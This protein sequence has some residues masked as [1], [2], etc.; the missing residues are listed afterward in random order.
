MED[1]QQLVY[2]AISMWLLVTKRNEA[3]F[4]ERLR[5]MRRDRET[6][7]LL[8]AISQR[9]S[10]GDN[11]TLARKK[12]RLRRVS[13]FHDFCSSVFRPMHLHECFA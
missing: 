9:S 13:Y 4:Q 7:G 8:E 11:S 1:I 2:F 6:S 5:A 3:L 10:A 12:R